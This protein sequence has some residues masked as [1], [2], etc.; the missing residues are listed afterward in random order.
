MVL[1]RFLFFLKSQ[2]RKQNNSNVPKTMSSLLIVA[3]E[4]SYGTDSISVE[5]WNKDCRVIIGKYC[6]I[7]S[8][9]KVILGGH[10]SQWISTFPFAESQSEAILVGDREGHP[11]MYGDVNI[12]NDVWIGSSVTIIGGVHIHDGAIIAAGSHVVSDVPAYSVFGGNPAK[13]I[14]FR[15]DETI[16]SK[17][18]EIKWWGYSRSTIQTFSHLLCQSPT[19]NKLDDLQNALEQSSDF[20][21]N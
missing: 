7:G 11:L 21:T 5:T 12:H 9:L 1:S 2:I 6:S 14:K 20:N 19:M 13:F 18:I 16:V 17:L 3:D 15:F 4:T 8:N 10:N